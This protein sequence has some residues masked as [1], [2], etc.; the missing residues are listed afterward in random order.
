DLGPVR[1]RCSH[2]AQ[3]FLALTLG[4]RFI[5]KRAN[6]FV[7]ACVWHRIISLGIFRNLPCHWTAF[8]FPFV[9]SAIEN[10]NLLVTEQ[11]ERPKRVTR[12]PVCLVA[13]ENA[14]RVWGDAVATAKL[15]KFLRRN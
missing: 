2:V 14:G 13:V 5:E 15:R 8:R 10:F 4:Q 12:P 9:A 7:E 6:L 3:G 1:A 11:P